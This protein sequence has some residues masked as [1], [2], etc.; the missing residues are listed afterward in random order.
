MKRMIGLKVSDVFGRLLLIMISSRMDKT[1]VETGEPTEPDDSGEVGSKKEKRRK[2]SKSGCGLSGTN[3]IV[4][5]SINS[6]VATNMG[7][8]RTISI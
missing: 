3:G 4:K 5:I 2:T 7:S 6:I 1:T 8:C